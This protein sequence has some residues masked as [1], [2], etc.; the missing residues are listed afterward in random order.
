MLIFLR[1]L[2]TEENNYQTYSSLHTIHREN[3]AEVKFWQT[4]ATGKY[5]TAHTQVYKKHE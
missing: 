2:K 4:I 5:S 1:Y 3:F